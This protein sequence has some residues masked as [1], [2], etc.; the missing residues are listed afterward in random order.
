MLID[1]TAADRLV[2]PVCTRLREEFADAAELPAAELAAWA[3]P[4]LRRAAL[5]GLAD[6]EHAALY[7][8]CAWLVGEDFDRA[9]AEPHAILTGSDPAATKAAAL[10]A[11]LDR[12]LD[13]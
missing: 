11:W 7:A 1:L 8:I 2:E 13:A 5:H 3:K 4:Q 9:C 6:E 10:E 12:L